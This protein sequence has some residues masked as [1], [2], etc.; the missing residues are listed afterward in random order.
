MPAKT[1]EIISAVR[2]RLTAAV[3]ISRQHSPFRPA[4]AAGLDGSP[5]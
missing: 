3:P 2:L 5:G 4:S 1:A